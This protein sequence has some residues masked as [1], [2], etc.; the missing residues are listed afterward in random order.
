MPYITLYAGFVAVA[1]LLGLGYVLSRRYEVSPYTFAGMILLIATFF[2][3][4][5]I[6]AVKYGLSPY[7]NLLPHHL[8]RCYWQIPSSK[9]NSVEAVLPSGCQEIPY[10]R[11]VS[12]FLSLPFRNA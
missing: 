9:A 6:G 5:W 11:G 10:S 8:A 3:L 1:A 4:G 7:W 12:C 2:S